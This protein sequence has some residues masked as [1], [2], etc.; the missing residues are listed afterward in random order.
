M[1][2][3]KIAA[4]FVA[5]LAVLTSHFPLQAQTQ[6]ANSVPSVARPRGGP[7]GDDE[8]FDGQAYYAGSYV[9][10]LRPPEVLLYVTLV[11]VLVVILQNNGH[12]GHHH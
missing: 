10:G 8:E 5:V 7:P 9:P 4:A 12:T 11:S 6:S 1:T 2:R 3:I